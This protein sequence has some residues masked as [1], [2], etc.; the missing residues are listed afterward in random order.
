MREI[1]GETCLKG[2]R[3]RR[4]RVGAD[5]L[6][7]VVGSNVNEVVC[8]YQIG[9]N[10]V[11]YCT[12]D[13]PSLC[14]HVSLIFDGVSTLTLRVHYSS[15]TFSN[16][17][18]KEV[19]VQSTLRSPPGNVTE[20]DHLNATVDCINLEVGQMFA[21]PPE[22]EVEPY[23]S[24]ELEWIVIAIDCNK[25]SC[26]ILDYDNSMKNI[27]QVREFNVNDVKKWSIS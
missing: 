10:G 13:D 20:E 15:K 22:E 18:E 1:F 17:T 14:N 2:H 23:L 24:Y 12:R 27:A 21:V 25:C 9:D 19:F 6:P 11:I 5:D 4:P 8:G 7:V 16:V 3:M 26:E